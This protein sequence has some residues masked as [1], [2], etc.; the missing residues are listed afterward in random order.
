MLARCTGGFRQ[1][2]RA[3]LSTVS[4][5]Q[6]D[7]RLLLSQIVTRHGDRS[8]AVNF[9]KTEDEATLWTGRLPDPADID[10]AALNFPVQSLTKRSPIDGPLYPF[11]QLS[12]MGMEQHVNLG[13]RLAARCGE[14]YKTGNRLEVNETLRRMR[15]CAVSTN[16][17]RTQLSAQCLLHG[18]LSEIGADKFD[19]E[20]VNILVKQT[21]NDSINTFDR[22]GG[23]SLG[24]LCRGMEATAL[25][26]EK[27]EAM[28]PVKDKLV[29]EIE[30][31]AA[32]PSIFKWINAADYFACAESHGDMVGKDLQGE[33][34]AAV[35]QHLHWKFFQWYSN[36][37]LLRVATGP[38]M[39]E[40]NFQIEEAMSATGGDDD[41]PPKLCLYSGHDVSILMLHHAL[42]SP[43]YT[44]TWW[45]A[46]AS[47]VIVELVEHRHSRERM[48]RLAFD[49]DDK[50]DAGVMLAVSEFEQL[51]AAVNLQEGW[52]GQEHKF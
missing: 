40:M 3:S 48:L 22:S 43:T 51:S 42:K 34:E 47:H 12:K 4:G 36:P 25:F 37:E 52:I 27:E 44:Q 17:K 14:Y 23:V 29:G 13:R 7:Y 16:Y 49:V 10:A 6:S 28:Q 31:F 8:P 41:A 20:D 2:A 35:W 26:T 45:P 9:S 33:V 39:A 15:V 24:E 38:L 46:Y 30:L 50:E 32:D 5:P 11:A 1:S 18:F 19:G 21:D